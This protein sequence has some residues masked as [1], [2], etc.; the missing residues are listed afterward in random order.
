MILVRET[1]ATLL[2]EDTAFSEIATGG[3]YTRVIK[4][5]TGAGATP[6]AFTVNPSDPAKTIRL[7]PAVSLIDAG[8][9]PMPNDDGTLGASTTFI[10]ANYHAPATL[11]GK[12]A[13]DGMDRRL[14]EVLNKTQIA[15]DG[16]WPGTLMVDSRTDV[17]DSEV[18]PGSVFCG[19]RIIIEWA[20]G[21]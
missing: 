15:I 16:M 8:E 17:L 21:A 7:L 4:P 6:T 13:I 2:A 9:F 10:I 3:V 14:Y 18:I 5:G 12:T 20:R 11:A 19:R 1:I